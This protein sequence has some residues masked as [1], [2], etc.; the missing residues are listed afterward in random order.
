MGVA[1]SGRMP[2][3]AGRLDIGQW[4]KQELGRKRYFACA[5]TI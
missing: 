5:F 4:E 3:N 1:A 2:L